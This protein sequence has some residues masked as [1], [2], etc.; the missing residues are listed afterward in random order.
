MAEEKIFEKR[1]GAY[2]QSSVVRTI[3]NVKGDIWASWPMSKLVMH[4]DKMVIKVSLQGEFTIEY[5]EITSL[6]KCFMGIQVHHNNKSIK[7]V[8]YL[9]G[10]GNGK[11]LFKKIKEIIQENKLKIKIKE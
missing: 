4:K 10:M 11:I 2:F 9:T 5:K 8:V 1:I 6:E 3:P 7:P